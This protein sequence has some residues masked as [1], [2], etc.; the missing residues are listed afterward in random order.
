MFKTMKSIDLKNPTRIKSMTIF[1]RRSLLIFIVLIHNKGKAT[2]N[3]KIRMNR[4]KVPFQ[5]IVAAAKGVKVAA[6]SISPP[7]NRK[8]A[9][10]ATT[11]DT[12]SKA[13]FKVV[14]FIL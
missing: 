13:H 12:P 5:F 11:Q 10:P 14:S 9:M 4:N 8:A 3:G 1:T 6:C 7:N 2:A